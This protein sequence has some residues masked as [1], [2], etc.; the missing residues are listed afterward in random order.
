[1]L[2]HYI[3]S[4]LKQRE[5]AGF[6]NKEW[7]FQ[8][9]INSLNLQ[10]G[11]A[12]LQVLLRKL[13]SEVTNA[14]ADIIVAIDINYNLNILVEGSP[15]VVRF[16]LDAFKHETIF[17]VWKHLKIN[18]SKSELTKVSG[19]F[20]VYP[21]SLFKSSFPFSNAIQGIVEAELKTLSTPGKQI[22]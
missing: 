2:V 9:A 17:D 5:E 16:W 21:K 15:V 6:L 19:R 10:S 12:F 22:L 3:H 11:G 18:A 7:I 20:S 14:L 4:N 13:G 8:E 1:M